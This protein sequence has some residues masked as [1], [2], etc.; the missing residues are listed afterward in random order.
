MFGDRM[1]A[2]G[3]ALVGVLAV[4]IYAWLNI[5]Y[6]PSSG[7][8]WGDDYALHLPNLLAGCYWGAHS[9]LALPWFS[10]AQ[11]GGVPYLADLNVAYYSLPQWLAFVLGPVPAVRATFVIFAA[12][13]ACGFFAL[14]VQRFGSSQQAALTGAV[15][16]LF[17][18]FYTARMLI[19]HL[20]FHPFA[21]IP[22]V[23]WSL[24]TPVGDWRQT[25]R[26]VVLAGL[27]FAYMFHAGMVH[28]IPPVFLA[29]IVIVAVHG[30]LRGHRRGPW[31]LLGAA[32]V[33]AL[34]ISAQ[35]LVAAAAFLSQFPR[36][37]Y[38]LPGFPTLL[39][40]ARE[41]LVLLFWRAP[42]D[43]VR[44]LTNVQWT[45][46]PGEFAFSVGPAALIALAAGAYG[47]ARRRSMPGAVWIWLALLL[48]GCVP[49]LLNWYY[50]PWNATLKTLPYFSSSSILLRWFAAYIPIV[51]LFAALA[52]DAA[53]RARW[54]RSAASLSIVACTVAWTAAVDERAGYDMSYDASSIQRAWQALASGGRVPTVKR[55]VAQGEAHDLDRNDALIRG[56]SELRCYQPTFGYRLERMPTAPLR[57]A[58]TL[59]E[60]APGLLNVKNPACYVYPAA[61]GCVPGAHFSVADRGRAERFLAY[62]PFDFVVPTALAAANVLTLM[63]LLAAV[64]ALPIS[65]L[66]R[67]KPC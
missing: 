18:G 24:L 33:L 58:P 39:G 61:N 48:L 5:G 8:D 42:Y 1:E 11:C 29:L 41:A 51:V 35:R 43:P 6:L 66:A 67:Q 22:W 16:F 10:P 3:C 45:P 56:E 28:G 30:Q 52:V 15:L 27:A 62:R 12:L 37:D 32:V 2:T 53:V 44:L 21:L 54:A 26:G 9:G 47:L 19:G 46:A 25:I 63:A 64:I 59:L 7:R 14:L 40:A 55:I 20:T 17:S 36:T 4:L 13:G 60:T 57:V 31:L 38:L 50:E 65:A 23:A 49:I 34:A